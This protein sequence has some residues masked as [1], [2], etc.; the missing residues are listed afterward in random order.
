VLALGTKDLLARKNAQVGPPLPGMFHHHSDTPALGWQ[1]HPLKAGSHIQEGLSLLASPSSLVLPALVGFG[2]WYIV[3]W[4]RGLRCCCAG[5]GDTRT[6]REAVGC[7]AG[8]EAA[9][10]EAGDNAQRSRGAGAAPTE[11]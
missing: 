11:C 6:H 5:C 1:C 2:V 7:S 3:P 9:C 8:G 4:V 10:E